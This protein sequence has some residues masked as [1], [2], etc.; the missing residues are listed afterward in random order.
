[1]KKAFKHILL[2]VLFFL[3]AHVMVAGVLPNGL[4]YYIVS[5]P[6]TKGLADFAL[7]QK[8][9]TSDIGEQAHNVAQGALASLPR[10]QSMTPQ[11][12]LVSSGV[13]AD[14]NGFVKVMEDATIYHFK[15]IVLE[16]EN[17]DSLLLVMMDIVGKTY[18][19]S[20]QAVVISGDVDAA[21]Y[22]SKLK[23][24]SYMISAESPM[25]RGE[26]RAWTGRENAEFEIM[27]DSSVE[28]VTVTASWLSARIPE[29]F[30]GT[31]RP[32]ICSMFMNELGLLAQERIEQRLRRDGVPVA[33]LGYEYKGSRDNCGPERLSVSL[34]VAP[35]NAEKAIIALASTLSALEKGTAAVHEVEM[36]KRK[37][38]TSLAKRSETVCS[39]NAAQVASCVSAFL[40]NASQSSVYDEYKF[41]KYRKVDPLVELGYFNGFASAVLD[42]QRNLSVTCLTNGT[43]GMSAEDVK[44]TFLRAWDAEPDTFVCAQSLDSLPITVSAPA[45]KLKSSK[46]DPFSG[47]VV[48]TFSNGFKVVYKRQDTSRRMYYALALNG[49]YGNI[50][51][52]SKGEGAYVSDYIKLSRVAE[53]DARSFALELE[54]NEIVLNPSVNMANTIIEGS[55]PEIDVEKM[56]KVI[57][58][59]VREREYDPQAFEYYKSCLDVQRKTSEGGYGRRLVAIDSLM[60]PAYGYSSLKFSGNI[61]ED[62]PAKVEAF[63]EHQC[64]KT[65]DGVLVL[66][67][68]IEETWLRKMLQNHIGDFMTTDRGYQRVNVSYQPESGATTYTVKG[69]RCSIDV[70]MSSQM[71]FTSE[72][73]VAGKIAAEILKQMVSEALSGTGMYMDLAHE[74]RIYPHERFSVMI[75]LAE[76]DPKGLIL[77]EGVSGPMEV[78]S[79]LRKVLA[80]LPEVKITN[81]DIKHWKNMMKAQRKVDVQDPQYW[82]RAVAMRYLDGKDLTTAYDTKVDAVTP[83]RVMDILS[84]LSSTSR[85]EYITEK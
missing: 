48:W 73:H 53:A 12:F 74:F 27:T 3:A 4:S 64:R 51:G 30:M 34:T 32:S 62:F 68:N 69:D 44:D 7:V 47:G 83:E 77:E 85:I 13:R 67:G 70:V 49:G 72:N 81:D 82:I 11:S 16:K 20:D 80:N 6:K 10:L 50:R 33:D 75:T 15:D 43:I 40:Y 57:S 24:L 45:V 42:G 78:L 28:Y 8:V 63:W 54:E 76:A 21:L 46:P 9:G 19:P 39:S 56:I 18:S 58:T 5:N 17:I 23:M 26:E 66:V 55:A 2:S 37:Y 25:E 65:N 14:K 79:R 22:E 59:F 61:T 1:M 84:S 38:L 35:E 71:A 41:L 52:L 36:V 60:C 31:V 29:D